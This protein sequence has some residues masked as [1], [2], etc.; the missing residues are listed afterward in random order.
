MLHL[1]Y[2]LTQ[3]N[4]VSATVSFSAR[5]TLR[6]QL[7]AFDLYTF[8]PLASIP[9]TRGA[10]CF[11]V[12]EARR[13]V[14]V[15]N[16]KRLQVRRRGHGQGCCCC[17]CGVGDASVEVWVLLCSIPCIRSKLLHWLVRLLCRP[18][19]YRYLF[20][21]SFLA[22]S[23]PTQSNAYR[24]RSVR[25]QGAYCSWGRSPFGSCGSFFSRVM[26]LRTH[27]TFARPLSRQC[28]NSTVVVLLHHRGYLEES[29]RASLL[30]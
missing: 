14:F 26:C 20:L 3:H 19:K 21:P 2:P 6:P 23:H 4:I 1:R 22:S 8:R 13:L 12:D 30:S 11:C 29:A 24:A 10:S 28:H 5:D 17:W 18:V 25:G 16:K 15:A 7:T 27:Q 9:S